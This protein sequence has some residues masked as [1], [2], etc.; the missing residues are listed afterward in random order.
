MVSGQFVENSRSRRIIAMSIIERALEKLGQ[1]NFTKSLQLE[2]DSELIVNALEN[3]NACPI[4]DS[5]P[6]TMSTDNMSEQQAEE[7]PIPDEVSDVEHLRS[8]NN[9]SVQPFPV[10]QVNAEEVVA[11]DEKAVIS[12]INT[13]AVSAPE[14]IINDD[15]SGDVKSEPESENLASKD[16]SS[17]PEQV[18]VG[19][20]LSKKENYYTRKEKNSRSKVIESQPLFYG[21]KRQNRKFFAKLLSFSKKSGRTGKVKKPASEEL[22]NEVRIPLTVKSQPI[23]QSKNNDGNN[24]AISPERNMSPCCPGNI[25][26]PI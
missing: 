26:R 21:K 15:D 20:T 19:F 3:N 1:K 25:L 12:N 17:Q 14:T 24:S 10:E 22:V 9:A 5:K 4:E 13:A 6:Q 8:A 7:L 2:P 23:R 18:D 11:D 16:D